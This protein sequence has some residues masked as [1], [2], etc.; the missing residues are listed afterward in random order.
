MVSDD[1]EHACMTAAAF[2]ASGGTPAAFVQELA[3]R[4]RWWL[5]A[6]PAGAGLATIRASTRLWLGITPAS[7]G[8][9][10][11][12]SGPAM[13]SPVLG[14]LS[15]HDPARMAQLVRV[16]T[17]LTHTDPEA[18][19]GALAGAAAAAVASLHP[20]RSSP[21]LA[22]ELIHM[23]APLLP[24]QS[25]GFLLLL[26]GMRESVRGGESTISY[27]DNLGLSRGVSG[28]ICHTVP[29]ALHAWLS[30]PA[31]YENAVSSVIR[32]GGDTDTTA[33]L[34]GSI[35]G[36]A[37]GVEQIP[38]QWRKGVLDWPI[39]LRHLERIANAAAQA[40]LSGSRESPPEIRW[41]Q[42][43]SRNA[44]FAL[45]VCAH[46]FRRLLPPY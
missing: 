27:A 1:T 33:A 10:S 9:Y 29:I 43:L 31:D 36:A 6:L 21:D 2:A 13:R 30:F 28:Y 18:E 3:L 32:C 40:A 26:E 23:L 7:S 22:G 45:L 15:A 39:S 14:V 34:T 44:I 12:G 11:A 41:L 4:M 16:S 8:V 38:A 20:G 17:R 19:W 46:G 42:A 35:S 24:P 37:N 5:A 25:E